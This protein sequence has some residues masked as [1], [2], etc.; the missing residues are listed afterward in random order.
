MRDVPEYRRLVGLDTAPAAGGGDAGRE[1]P[2][3]AWADPPQEPAWWRS[4]SPGRVTRRRRLRA[5]A[6]FL[7]GVCVTLAAVVYV[8]V[9]GVPV[10]GG[11]PIVAM[12]PLVIPPGPA[13]QPQRIPLSGPE[14]LAVGTSVT[15][16]GTLPSVEDGRAVVVRVRWNGGAWEGL[17]AALAEDDGSFRVAYVLDRAGSAQVRIVLPDGSFAFKWYRV[18]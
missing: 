14:Q 11:P 6:W 2:P 10:V 18:G 13:G 8:N 9:R 1:P 7:L 4:L 16:E 3:T 15:V 17:H 5:S 12:D